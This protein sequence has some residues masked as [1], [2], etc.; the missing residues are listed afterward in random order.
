[1]S[2]IFRDTSAATAVA[3]HLAGCI[4]AAM[5]QRWPETIR[6]LIIHSAEW[7]PAMRQQFD[8]AVSEQQKRSLLRKYGYGVPSYERAVL[9][10]AND[11]TL[12]A[13]DEIQPSWKDGGTT[14]SHGLARNS[15]S[16]AKLKW[17]CE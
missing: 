8:A 3:G 5:P 16:S 2:D 14:I 1:V 6:A 15:E 9:S 13:E 7:I 11:L 12:I 17:N 10:A 4:L